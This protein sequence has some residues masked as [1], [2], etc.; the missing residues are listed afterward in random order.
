MR[1][2]TALRERL[3]DE[4]KSASGSLA[5]IVKEEAVA[6]RMRQSCASFRNEDAR[7]YFVESCE[8]GGLDAGKRTV[9]A[10]LSWTAA[11]CQ[12]FSEWRLLHGGF[13]ATFAAREPSPAPSEAH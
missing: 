11:G 2:A 10:F 6:K 4:L 8:V 13:Q 7:Y 5:A 1:D 9:E 12:G 3:E